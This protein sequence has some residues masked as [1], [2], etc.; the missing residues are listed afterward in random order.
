M[1]NMLISFKFKNFRSVREWKEISMVKTGQSGFA[2][3]YVRT[4]N[5]K[6]LLKSAVIY[7][8]NASGKSN[9][10]KAIQALEYLVLHSADY[11]VDDEIE[12]YE[13]FKL[14]KSCSA[15]PVELQINFFYE[16]TQY[17][18]AVAFTANRIESEDLYYYPTSSKSLLYSRVADKEMK[19]GDYYKGAKK[20][21]EKLTLPNQLFLSKASENNVDTLKDPYFFFKYGL[22]AYSTLGDYHERSVSRFYAKR[23]AEN[24]DSAFARRFNALICSL[25]TGITSVT[26]K[27]TV[28]PEGAFGN[29]PEEVK[30]RLKEEYRYEIKTHHPL[31]ENGKRIDTQVFDINDESTGTQS[32]FAIAGLLLDALDNGRVLVV[33][34]FEKSLHP[35][36]TKYFITLF[37]NPDINRKNAQLIFATHDV[38]QL[39][40]DHFRR[41]QV[42]FTYKDDSGA[43]DLKRCSDI[44]G[45]RLGTPI[46]RWYIN[47]KLGSVPILDERKFLME[48]LNEEVDGAE[49]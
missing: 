24:S 48:I 15:K 47:G 12:P 39:S 22:N 14:D 38:S 5:K 36:I 7:G 16:G 8:P 20:T 32:L 34:E 41:D 2:G 3:N 25:D 49:K 44:S 42:W 18:Y 10:L 28:W 37:H 21:L 9:I 26:A 19:F 30:N 45:L 27:E 33:D 23:L 4:A 6:Q 1:I 11:K 13:P 46:D 43:T 40:N 31:F 29:V 17:D 35:G